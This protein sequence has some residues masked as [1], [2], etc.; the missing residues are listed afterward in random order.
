MVAMTN[1]LV[2][3]A[4]ES[5][6]IP[7]SDWRAQIAVPLGIVLFIGSVYMLVRAN[8]GTRRGYLVTATSLFGFMII[9]SLF[10]TF[11]A[12]GTPPATGPQNL[13][14]QEL[15]AYEDVWRP[16]AAD[17]NLASDPNY[18]FA[19]TYPE[20]Q[21]AASPAQAGLPPNAEGQAQDG[22]DDIKTFFSTPKQEG[23]PLDDPPMSPFWKPNPESLRYAKAP[24]GRAVIG[25][26]FQRTW[27]V[28]DLPPNTEPPEGPPP[29]TPDGETVVFEGPDA[30]VAPEGTE[31]GDVVEGEFAQEY[32]AF[33]FFDPG[34]PKFPSLVTFF[35]M[36]VLFIIH[37]LLLALD[38]RREHR[39][40][41]ANAQQ[42]VAEERVPAGA[43]RS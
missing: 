27:Q 23:G 22:I 3:L 13:P 21:W 6:G 1:W 2:V 37:A 11:G 24:N 10:W 18:S 14:G 7:G 36:L 26:E 33:A 42:P 9:Y 35:L 20:G 17:S 16:F 43:T 5:H 40:R 41:E 25:V 30:N 28:G 32:R 29:L 12:P 4:T 31:I 19:K 39:E 38:E 8:L 15:D 34:S